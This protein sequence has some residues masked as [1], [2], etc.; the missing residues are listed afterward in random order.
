MQA[1][2]NAIWTTYMNKS[3]KWLP[4]FK[5]DKLIE[6]YQRNKKYYRLLPPTIAKM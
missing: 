3:N 1:K 4:I 5:Y 2:L 6:I